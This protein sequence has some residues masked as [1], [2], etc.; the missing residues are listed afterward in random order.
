MSRHEKQ[1][2]G[3]PKQSRFP[4][5]WLLDEHCLTL[6][7]TASNVRETTAAPTAELPSSPCSTRRRLAPLPNAFT[8]RS[9]CRASIT[10][11][12]RFTRQTKTRQ[13]QLAQPGSP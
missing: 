11:P 13:A 3:A 8:T 5:H 10:D 9:N 1:V 2:P 12:L 4:G 7:A 6:A